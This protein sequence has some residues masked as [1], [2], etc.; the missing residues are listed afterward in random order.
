MTQNPANRRK[1]ERFQPY[2]CDIVLDRKQG[3]LMKLLGRKQANIALEILD[4]SESGVRI[5]TSQKMPLQTE[6]RVHCGL[7]ALKDEL[8]LEG[9]VL[10]CVPHAYRDNEFVVGITFTNIDSPTQRKIASIRSYLASPQF[11]QKQETRVRM[12]PKTQ[13]RLEFDP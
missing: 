11:K 1:H 3:V 10:W 13:P 7:K 9:Q 8:T 2:E 4:L 6:V 5:G 12:K